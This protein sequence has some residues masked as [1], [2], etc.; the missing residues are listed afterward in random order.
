[1]SSLLQQLRA[2]RRASLEG[3]SEIIRLAD[4]RPSE[5]YIQAIAAYEAWCSGEP[6]TALRFALRA[7][8]G[9]DTTYPALLVL[10]A[11]SSESSDAQ[12]TYLYASRLLAAA[13]SNQRAVRLVQAANA[14][15]LRS[16]S[17]QRKEREHLQK[18]AET[19][20]KWVAWAAE[21]VR[22]H[23]SLASDV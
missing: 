12:S 8:R 5:E 11:I 14:V 20:T 13:K 19:H 3:L 22:N 10:T 16:S 9:D 4:S 1:M 17:Q 15:S 2:A 18:T 23:E 21:F 7:D 6:E